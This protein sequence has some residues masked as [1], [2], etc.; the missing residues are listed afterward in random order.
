MTGLPIKP[1]FGSPCN[2]CG[3]CCSVEPCALSKEFIGSSSAPCVALERDGDKMICGL[4]RR[5]AW[6]LF[7]EIV[8]DSETGKLSSIFAEALG[9]GLGCDSGYIFIS[10]VES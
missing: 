1:K 5:P 9:I 8:Q 6:Y 4:V 2:G 10:G 3:Q 7:G